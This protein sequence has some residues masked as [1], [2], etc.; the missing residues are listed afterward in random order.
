MGGLVGAV[1]AAGTV[2]IVVGV[3]LSPRS[4]RP[5][6]WEETY[7]EFPSGQALGEQYGCLVPD[8]Q[9]LRLKETSFTASFDTPEDK[10]ADRWSELKLNYRVQVKWWGKGKYDSVYL[11]VYP[12]RLE[13]VDC[14]HV[15]VQE[16]QI[17]ELGG[18]E[19]F[20]QRERKEAVFRSGDF[21][22]VLSVYAQEEGDPLLKYLQRILI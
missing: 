10:T 12:E 2:L 19:V 17:M 6:N 5:P 15:P 18:T 7:R 8:T 9:G 22:Y 4:G 13:P 14:L 20:C 11:T 21:T 1:I 3:L 16:I